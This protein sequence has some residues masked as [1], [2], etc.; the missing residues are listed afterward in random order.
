MGRQA[1]DENRLTGSR[2]RSG[3]CKRLLATMTYALTEPLSQACP[4]MPARPGTKSHGN[5]RFAARL[6]AMFA[7][8]SHAYGGVIRIAKNP[9]K[10]SPLT[11]S[12]RRP[13][14]YHSATRR[15]ARASAGHGDH[16][17]PGNPSI[18]HRTSDRGLTRVPALVFQHCSCSPFMKTSRRSRSRRVAAMAD[19]MTTDSRGG[20]AIGLTWL[21]TVSTRRCMRSCVRT[22][23]G[24][25]SRIQPSGSVGGGT[26]E[27][28]NGRQFQIQNGGS[29]WKQGVNQ[30]GKMTL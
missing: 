3:P 4:R 6:R 9:C 18:R 17:S 11:D 28:Y 21:P 19:L 10:S 16:K 1:L 8:R 24:L 20:P 23:A 7:W 26:L 14:P 12:N 27:R 13:P 15:E 30:F 5:A 2:P 22:D 25:A 29:K